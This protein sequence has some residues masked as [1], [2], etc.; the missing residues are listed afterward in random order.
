MMCLGVSSPKPGAV[1]LDERRTSP[2][3]M[4]L[5]PALNTC[6]SRLAT[7]WLSSIRLLRNHSSTSFI[8]ADTGSSK[9]ASSRVALLSEIPGLNVP[10]MP[11]LPGED[12]LAF[13]IDCYLVNK[14]ATNVKQEGGASSPAGKSRAASRPGSR[15]FRTDSRDWTPW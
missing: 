13:H 12:C 4:R 7:N 3:R 11:A 15:R 1:A 14:T 6:D 2:G 5:P 10:V 9:E 8:S